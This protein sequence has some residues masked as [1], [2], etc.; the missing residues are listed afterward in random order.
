MKTIV[1]VDDEPNIL[2]GLQRLL[3]P[4]RHEWDMHFACGGR[5]ALDLMNERSVDVIVSDMRMPDMDGADLLQI[6]RDFFPST[7]RLILSGHSGHELIIKS[8]RATHQFLAKPCSADML[9]RVVSRCC[10][11]RDR[12]SSEPLRQLFYQLNLLPVD[13]A[14]HNEILRV[15]SRPEPAVDAVASLVVHDI[16]ISAKLLQLV[17]SPFFGFSGRV[18]KPREAVS[19]LGIDIMRLLFDSGIFADAIVSDEVPFYQDRLAH[20]RAV[21]CCAKAIARELWRDDELADHAFTC[22]LL[23][24]VGHLVLLA[25]LA[26]IGSETLHL[27]RQ[28]GIPQWIVEKEWI[29]ASHSDIGA[30]L[31]DLWGLPEA[32][33][34]AIA[35]HHEPALASESGRRL[36]AA[37]HIADYLAGRIMDGH[38][39]PLDEAFVA[40][41]GLLDQLDSL[42]ITCEAMIQ[43][44]QS[45][46]SFTC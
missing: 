11:L 30:C 20:S 7:A 29:G 22:G 27:A 9:T 40:G 42:R 4:M 16:A 3:R 37:V 23:H 15:L 12:L 21:A 43:H 17:S 26:T 13:Q 41:L 46:G 19:L 10:K 35:C 33:V 1:F 36:V 32:I 28:Q 45:G 34:E 44:Q 24:D 14:I 18:L 5:E 8:I 38:S 6:V 2:K 39:Q 25:N 31:M